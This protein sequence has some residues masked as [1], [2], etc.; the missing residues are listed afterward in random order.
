MSIKLQSLKIGENKFRKL[1]KLEIQFSD[2]ITVI[3]GLNGIGK[4]TILGLIANSSGIRSASYK[5]YFDSVFQS[6]FQELFHLDENDDYQNETDSKSYVD[7][8]YVINENVLTKRCSVSRHSESHDDGTTSTRLKIVPR[9]LE[10]EL[11]AELNV[12]ESAKIQ[13]PTLYLGMSRMTPIGEYE[14]DRVKQTKI[15][16]VELIDKDYIIQLFKSVV[17]FDLSTQ[18]SVDPIIDHDFKGSKKRSKLPSLK[19]NT[20]SI[21]LGQDSLSSI[22]TALASFKKIKRE[23]GEDYPGGLLIIDELDAGLHHVAQ[24][25]LIELLKREA[26]ALNLQI[27]F[28]THSLTIFKN[29]LNIP[30]KQRS[31]GEI[32]DTVIYLHN[33]PAPKVTSNPTYAWIK[34][35]QLSQVSIPTNT[36]EFQ[37]IKVYL[38]DEEA[39]FF[40][41]KILSYKNITDTSQTFGVNLQLIPLKVSCNGLINLFLADDYFKKVVIVPDNDILSEES[42]RSIV[43]KNRQF[44]PLPNDR[45][46]TPNTPSTDRNPEKIVYN[47]IK[48]KIINYDSDDTFWDSILSI[49]YGS[50]DYDYIQNTV[51]PISPRDEHGHQFKKERDKMKYWF[52]QH[53]SFLENGK[54][55]ELWCADNEESVSQ[56]V[57]AFKQSVAFVSQN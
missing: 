49:N 29:I 12:G 3:G 28:T 48:D 35:N 1:R 32:L 21:S 31:E 54:I 36:P 11:G 30:E 38:E 52:K 27:V 17:N 16:T 47:F 5:S 51:L 42:N 15:R 39:L 4:S 26:R 25:K 44:S 50:Y 41:N 9:T 24:I 13:L 7:I 55:I 8:T 34:N 46:F 22:F 20:L 14:K 23:M 45:L 56:F 37:N 40:L 53:K 57:E 19:H 10:K 43:N 6:N 2:R 18:A 33:T